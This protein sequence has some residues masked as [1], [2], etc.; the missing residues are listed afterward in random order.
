MNT[1]K[2][3][4]YLNLNDIHIPRFFYGTAWKEET[5]EDLTFQAL[6][7]GF[8]AIDT[9]NQRKH[10]FEEGVGLGLKK[11]LN[12][13]TLKRENIFLQTK[14]TF[15]RG[16]DHRKPYKDNDTYTQ[17]VADS[18]QSSL[19]HLNTTT[20]DSYVL[21]GPYSGRGIGA[22]DLEVWSAMENLVTQ[23]KVQFLGVSNVSLNQLEQLFDSTKIKPQFVQNRCFANMGWDKP[24][25]EFCLEKNII[26]QGFS[27]LTANSVEL[28]SSP[29]LE[30]ARKHNKTVA[31]IIFRFS[32][33]L[34]M[35]TLTG[36]SDENH[37]KQDL[38]IYNFELS[39]QEISTIEHIS[40]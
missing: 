32:Q 22:E 1:L 21:H 15:A 4:P 38:N 6:Q 14:F 23:Q 40:F 17:Q 35:I 3:T 8:L 12:L 11:F 20:L 19:T 10:Y 16:Q 26:Y 28:A 30:I 31:Q 24:V 36:T 7:S 9:A 29:I 5:T 18:F 34:G 25:R 39:A 37:M 2:L 33:Q 27:L 13:G